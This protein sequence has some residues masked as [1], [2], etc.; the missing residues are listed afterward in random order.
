MFLNCRFPFTVAIFCWLANTCSGLSRV[1]Q[2]HSAL[3]VPKVIVTRRVARP[4]DAVTATSSARNDWHATAAQ[5]PAA[6]TLTSSFNLAKSIVG[7][8]VLALP[9]GLAHVS[10]DR[11]VAM[12]AAALC[13]LYGSLAAYSFSIIGQVCHTYGV[14][15]YTDA[16]RVTISNSTARLVPALTTATCFLNMLACSILIGIVL[17]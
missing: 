14:A 7:M 16:Y 5:E 15:S 11:S 10:D 3:A 2:P 12:P 1:F 6:G 9:S 4:L 13:A 17:F 8:G